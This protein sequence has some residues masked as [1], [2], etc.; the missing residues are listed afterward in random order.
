MDSG[1]PK[2]ACVRWGAHGATWRISLN[3]PCAAAIRPFCQITLTTCC[4]SYKRKDCSDT[5]TERFSGTV[6]DNSH[7]SAYYVGGHELI[8]MSS[9]VVEAPDS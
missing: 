7:V 5:V 6:Q 9:I 4:Y 8:E 1:G 2:E 3:R